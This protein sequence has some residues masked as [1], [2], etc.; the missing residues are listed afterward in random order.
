ME[1]YHYLIIVI[2]V[3]LLCLFIIFPYVCYLLTFYIKNKKVKKSAVVT[4]PDDQLFNEFRE[5]VIQ[6]IIWTRSLPKQTFSIKSHDGLTL[7]GNYYEY[8]KDS[9]IEI[10]FH[11]YKG[12]G[13]RD[14][15]TGVRRAFACKRSALVV[16]QRASGDS[17]GHTTTFGINE[18]HDC[19][20]WAKFVSQLFPNRKIILTGISMGAATV[21][22]ASAMELPENVIGILADCGYSKT[23]D[24]IKKVVAEMK[25]PVNLVYPFIKLGAKMFGHFN[26]EETSPYD[27]V[28]K[29]NLPIIFYHG[30]IDEIVP[31]TMS[32]E[33]YNVCSSSKKLVLVENAT[34]GISFLKDPDLYINSLNEFFK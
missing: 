14:L 7:C 17:E 27:A 21:M 20:N 32:E 24:I 26:L 9:P 13:E 3:L 33:L 30:T 1:W 6:D 11:G 12:T 34:H 18:R 31:H 29:T 25:L 16:D 22:M 5:E 23:S 2:G 4:L 15:S 28:Q 10:M 19:V 8:E